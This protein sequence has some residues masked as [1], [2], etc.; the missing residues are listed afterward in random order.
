MGRACRNWLA[1]MLIQ[2]KADSLGGMTMK[3]WSRSGVLAMPEIREAK[4]KG[5]V[6]AAALAIVCFLA[7]TLV[8][9][10]MQFTRVRER[11][12]MD[13]L[14]TAKAMSNSVGQEL[15]DILQFTQA[16]NAVLLPDLLERKFSHAHA[17]ALRAVKASQL[18]HHIALTEHSGQQVLNT[19]TEFGA[20]LP[21]T[22]NL[23]RI[24]E[25]FKTGKP[26]IS[27]LSRG[28]ISRQF[29]IFVDVPVMRDGQVI[30]VLTSV[31]NV[32]QLDKV[33]SSQNLSSDGIAVVFDREAVILART[34]NAHQFVGKKV[35][36]LFQAELSRRASGTFQN[37]TLEGQT[38]IAAFDR[39]AKSGFGV[40]IGFPLE[41][42]IRESAGYLPV[43]ALISLIAILAL[44]TS[45]QYAIR[46]RQ[47]RESEA[48]L[49]QFVSSTPAALAMFDR[50]GN[51]LANSQRWADVFKV[52]DVS[53]SD[54][55]AVEGG[56]ARLPQRWQGSLDLALQGKPSHADEDQ[57]GK[58][59]WLR[60]DVRPWLAADGKVGGI[61]VLSEDIS[62]RKRAE[63]ALRDSEERFRRVSDNAD[64]GLVRCDRNW[65]YQ[66]ANPA[67]ARLV[68]RSVDDIVGQPLSAIV[69]KETLESIR[70]YVEQALN[71]Q[72]VS[73]EAAVRYQDREPLW[74]SVS[75][76]P[77][78]D[79]GGNIGG[80]VASISDITERKQVQEAIAQSEAY[81][82]Q[83]FNSM[84]NGYAHC[85][86]LY[87]G[88]SPV[89]FI[90]LRVNPAFEAQ[91]GLKGVAGRRVSEVIPGIRESDPGLFDVYSR[92]ARGGH[93]EQFEM[94]VEALQ[95][96]FSV[97]VF[98]PGPDQFV[99]VFDVVT[100]RKRA[101]AELDRYRK[102]LEEQVRQRTAD[103]ADANEQLRALMQASSNVIYQMNG[104]WTEMSSLQGRDFIPDTHEPNRT[105]LDRYIPPENQHEVMSVI[106]HAIQT[107]SAFEL[108]HPVIRT[109]GSIGWTYS[110]AIPVL[111]ENGDVGKW[112]GMAS[113]ITAE[114]AAEQA[115]LQAKQDAERSAVAKSEFLANMSH[116][117]RTPLNGVLGMA[118]IGYRDSVGRHK[119]QETF[120]R[121][122]DS[123]KLLLTVINDILDFSKIE[124]GKLDVESVPLSPAK[125]I[126]D[127]S[128]TITNLAESN[129]EL[130]IE[131]T[132][133]PLAV[134]GDPVR[135]SQI[136]LN[137]LS[138]AVKFT[139]RGEVGL[140]ARREGDEL[141]FAVR[142]TGMGMAPEAI[143]RLFQ[144]FTQADTSTTRKFGGT[145]LGLV[146]SRRLAELMG[147]SLGVE[148]AV[149]KGSTFTLRLPLQETEAPVPTGVATVIGARRL[150]G[151]RLLVAEDN[152][153]NQIVIQ[154][155]LQGE[156]AEVALAE[157]GRQAVELV[158]RASTPF[159]AVL[160]DVQMPEMD[161]LEAT[162]LLRQSHPNLPVIGQT[163]H[164]LKEEH[165]KCQ[166]AGM[167]AIVQKPI[168]VEVMVSTVMEQVHRPVN[169]GRVLVPVPDVSPPAVAVT[170]DWAALER[171]YPG[172]KEFID[173]LVSL[174]LQTDGDDGNRMRALASEGDMVAIGRFAHDLKTLAGNVFATE[175][176]QLAMRTMDSARTKDPE[177]SRHANDLAD[178][179]DRM[180]DALRRGRPA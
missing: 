27:N 21:I 68:G 67:Y 107:R 176:Q 75:Y 133:L 117:I 49:R 122:L 137:L 175:A 24:H 88:D 128:Q 59:S 125:L 7:V 167:T 14:M 6:Q 33:L 104:D 163:S 98:S 97:S 134:L 60:W 32:S 86:M 115:L 57:V 99:S 171:R 178:A 15:G 26:R 1:S 162:A 19:L 139:E 108:R 87:E 63:Q 51:Y 74:L 116:E 95:A 92:V 152:T 78:V 164:A 151:L 25:V 72:R 50:N 159:D 140:S 119:A 168:D 73:Y 105:W 144:P 4:A 109:D 11:V 147:G 13:L 155:L 113:D 94:F 35:S 54:S 39:E 118:Q 8:A 79:A 174:T 110:R 111:D 64:V 66:S 170:V 93:P 135:I 36:E 34:R 85:Q 129:L 30:Y 141:V 177:T 91:T 62:E 90:Y 2:V 52:D 48:Q 28:T 136:L 123:G 96:W 142:D 126:D 121:I 138:N 61:V 81:L 169:A 179:L 37:V 29:E 70:P 42:V 100:E 157:N 23:D 12:E 149:G 154:N 17:I 166:A 143:V 55:A 114:K 43:T 10:W 130:R 120:S 150:A 3:N 173:R 82:R 161:G 83:L 102:S 101:E 156:G 38:T 84:Q 77:D 31:I 180:F 20:P 106:R 9:G 127:L 71:G 44:M 18:A 172:R 40:G 53:K 146:I 56:L 103:L 112:F 65:I 148:S 22:K 132:D 41:H 89:D 80:W 153:I 46:L 76:A 16:L 131:K 47:R 158:E 160:M 58:D 124:A 145:G 165:D 69:S 5:V 45:W